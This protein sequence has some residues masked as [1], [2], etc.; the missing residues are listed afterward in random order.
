MEAFQ[1]KSKM[2]KIKIPSL[3]T[4]QAAPSTNASETK[5]TKPLVTKKPVMIED[6]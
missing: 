2:H 4:I 6:P 1:L 5:T 3:H